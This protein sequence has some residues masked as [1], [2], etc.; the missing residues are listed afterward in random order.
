MNKLEKIR[1]QLDLI[2]NK[3]IKILQKRAKLI[4]KIKEVKENEKIRIKD[5]KREKYILEK[6]EN[7]YER[8]IFKKIL[9]ESRKLQARGTQKAPLQKPGKI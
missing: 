2:D 8:E 4:M 6:M 5:P 7:N 9:L 3:I 1:K